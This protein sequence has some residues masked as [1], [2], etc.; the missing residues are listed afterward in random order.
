MKPSI[1]I[2]LFLLAAACSGSDPNADC[3]YGKCDTPGGTVEEQC[4]NARVPSMDENRPHFTP[5]GVRWSCRDVNGVTSNSNESDDR[6]QEYC[7]YFSM[8]H[9]EGIPEVLM[10]EQGPV[11]CDSSTP[12]ARGTCDQ[13]IFSCV[14]STR[15][16]TSRPADIL[17]KNIDN[18]DKVTPLDPVLSAGQLEWL[19]QNPQEKVGE[20]VFTSWHKDITSSPSNAVTVAGYRLDARAPNSNIPLF[21]MAVQ[22]NS[23]G[24]AQELVK[25]CL[26]AGNEELEDSFMRGCTMCG[27][28]NCVPWRKSDPSVCTMA[29]RI[30][31]CGCQI[32]INDETGSSRTLDLSVA[33]DL[34]LARELFVPTSRRGFTLGTWDGMGQLP[35]GCRYVKM[36]DPSAVTVN[37][38]T[39]DDPH[40][41]QTL[42][43]CDLKASHITAATA[44]DPK[45]ACRQIY[46][47][48]VVVHVRAPLPGLATLSCDTT[49]PQC[50]G[51]PWDYSN[52]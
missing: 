34:L 21:R 50:Q 40:A 49:K 17:G 12:C 11:F 1:A 38:V 33:G 28:T 14:T 9:T 45:E 32:D 39:V 43:T 36:G 24:A 30:A 37:G 51:I 20:C 48:E 10:D 26:Q 13:S 46:G 23:N 52:L 18:R 42:V 7:E 47:E 19:S 31:E 4:T 3:E 6:G 35:T 29:M 27:D 5:A 8:L 2:P 25:D 16:D 41:D 22:F 44:K 15:V